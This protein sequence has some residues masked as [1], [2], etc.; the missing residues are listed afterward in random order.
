MPPAVIAR[1]GANL[2]TRG[3]PADPGANWVPGG[4]ALLGHATDLV[5]RV[6]WAGA[7]AANPVDAAAGISTIT[8]AKQIKEFL[9]ACADTL[10]LADPR[11]AARPGRRSRWCR[12]MPATP[13]WTSPRAT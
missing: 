5:E 10:C 4:A 2:A 8:L 7:R 12:R 3:H 6:P 9:T 1:L 13:R 11:G